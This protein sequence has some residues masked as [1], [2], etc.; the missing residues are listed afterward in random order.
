MRRCPECNYTRA[1]HLRDGRFKCKRC[2]K[3]YSWTSV[4]DACRL[5]D[6]IKRRLLE[7]F[8]L[9]VPIYRLRF[10]VPVSKRA[11]QRFFRLIRAVLALKEECREPFHGAIECDETTFGGRR[12][13]KRGWGASGKIIVFGILQRNGMVK[14]FPVQG[15]KGEEI[16]RLV[17]EHTKPGS[18]YYTDDWRAYGSLAIRGDHIVVKKDTGRPKGRSHINGIEGFWSYAK[19]WLYPYRGVPRKFFHLF[20]GEISFRFNHRHED[21]FPLIYKMLRSTGYHEIQHILVRNR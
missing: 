21:I 1:W 18:L 4:W 19:N 6:S 16:I 11:I 3:R 14:V 17:R 8:V 15:R 5:P 20:L 9:G 7:F 13:G 2:N 10:R 12:K